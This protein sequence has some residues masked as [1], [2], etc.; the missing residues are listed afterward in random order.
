MAEDVIMEWVFKEVWMGFLIVLRYNF[1]DT[2]TVSKQSFFELQLLP[3]GCIGGVV[4]L[5]VS[6]SVNP[7]SKLWEPISGAPSHCGTRWFI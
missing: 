7:L 4:E 3:L 5:F 1:E 2:T 6:E